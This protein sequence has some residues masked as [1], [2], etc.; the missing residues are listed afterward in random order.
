[1]LKQLLFLAFLIEQWVKF[2][3]HLSFILICSYLIL[4][5]ILKVIIVFPI[6][7]IKTLKRRSPILWLFCATAYFWLF[8]VLFT[9]RVILSF[10]PILLF[11]ILSAV[12]HNGYK[13]KLRSQIA[14]IWILL[15]PFIARRCSHTL[16]DLSGPRFLSLWHGDNN[17]LT[18]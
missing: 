5:F 1:M 13:S 6:L 12:W 7:Q 8:I 14:Q 17:N 2:L 3:K 15:L 16:L 18:E 9:G 10:P 11:Q 4:K